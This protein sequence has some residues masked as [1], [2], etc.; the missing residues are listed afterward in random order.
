MTNRSASPHNHRAGRLG[1]RLTISIAALTPF[2]LLA[3]PAIPA[4]AAPRL[5]QGTPSICSNVKASAVS[6]VVGYPVPPATGFTDKVKATRQN[7][8][9]SAVSTSCTFGADKSLT[10]L[11]KD[12]V[13]GL[14]VTSRP[15]TAAEWRQGMAAEAK[16]QIHLTPYSGLGMPAWYFTDS[17]DGITTQGMAAISRSKVYSAALY[18]KAS[19]ISELV[20]LV[21]LAE[22][23]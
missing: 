21:K 15:L 18:S 11:Q 17:E 19:V 12:A 8:G 23:L 14:E 20:A 22:K 6:A 5:A 7:F 9:I 13:L 2:S 1:R 10:D 3:T 16:L 4:L